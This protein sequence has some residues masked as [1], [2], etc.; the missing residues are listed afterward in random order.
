MLAL[1]PTRIKNDLRQ[2]TMHTSVTRQLFCIRSP[3]GLDLHFDISRALQ[4]LIKHAHMDAYSDIGN[5]HP[6]TADCSIESIL[7][8]KQKYFERFGVAHSELNQFQFL[9]VA[10]W[11]E[12][13]AQ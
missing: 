3:Y 7:H 11:N 13:C 12:S 6:S 5:T 10:F 8:S 9:F 1:Q 2:I 4:A